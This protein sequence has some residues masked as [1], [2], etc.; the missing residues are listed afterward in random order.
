MSFLGEIKRRKVFHVAVVYAVVAWALV[1][2]VATVD[3]PLGYHD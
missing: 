2:I 1:E 3:E